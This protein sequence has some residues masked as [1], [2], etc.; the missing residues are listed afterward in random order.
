M[1][2]GETTRAIVA[3]LAPT[4]GKERKLTPPWNPDRLNV[5]IVGYQLKIRGG[6]DYAQCRARRA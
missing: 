6:S 1:R 5:A 4:E 3:Q 2:D